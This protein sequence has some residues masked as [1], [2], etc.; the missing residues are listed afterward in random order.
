MSDDFFY[1]RVALY[2]AT[3]HNLMDGALKSKHKNLFINASM[4]II[5]N[6]T[7]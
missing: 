3:H 6:K 4:K 7:V 5:L 2:N 1:V